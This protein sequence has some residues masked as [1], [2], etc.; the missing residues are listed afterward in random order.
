[1][2]GTAVLPRR[3]AAPARGGR[4]EEEPESIPGVLHADHE[5]LSSEVNYSPLIFL[6]N[7]FHSG[8]PIYLQ[9]FPK[10]SLVTL[11]F[12]KS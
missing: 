10:H 3:L 12:L 4:V 7:V 1:M 9:G 8:F 5:S 6:E 11:H 2:A